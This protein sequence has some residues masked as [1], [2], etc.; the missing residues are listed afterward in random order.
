MSQPALLGGTPAVTA[1][2][3]PWPLVDA[4]ALAEITRVITEETLCPV[5]A[6]GTQGDFERAFAALHGRKFALAV[7]GGTAALMLALHGAG[8][9]PG[10]EVICSPFTWGAS[11]SCVLQNLA[12]PIFA[13]IDRNTFTLD[14]ASIEAKI[15]PRT[16]A[17]VVVHIFGFPAD[18]TRIMEVAKR[19]N[20]A[21][22]EDCAQAHG[23]KH[24]GRLVGSWG[25]VGAFSL[26][27]S[28]NLTGGE[29]GILVCDD[30]VVYERAMSMGTHPQRLYAELELPEF[31]E[32]IDSLAFNY[33][34]HSMS[35]AMANVQLKYLEQWTLARGRNARDLYDQVRD[36][37]FIEIPAELPETDRHAYYNIPFVYRPGIIPLSRTEFVEALKAEGVN[38]GIYVRVPLYLRPRFQNHDYFGRGYPWAIADEPVVYHKGDCPVAE[39]MAHVEF[40]VGG[41]YYVDSPELMA[42]VAAAMRKVGEQAPALRAYFDAPKASTSP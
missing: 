30:R 42:Q 29:G 4:E 7:N 31:R 24:A 11:V 40:Q 32:K 34:M 14:P 38:A 13:D 26:Q 39:A 25:T 8:V 27:A 15:T 10:D 20:L 36:L 37:P 1:A 23:G 21:V 41:N 6:E 12:I 16:K 5:G 28:K 18:M 3:P 2:L 35:A 9:Q 19:H 17:I 33:R 22:I